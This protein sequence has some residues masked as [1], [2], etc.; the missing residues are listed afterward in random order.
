MLLAASTSYVDWS[1][2]WQI[3]VIGL[4]AGAGLV[5]VYSFGL[6]FVAAAGGLRSTSAPSA[7]RVLSLVAAAVCFLAVVGGVAYGISVMLTK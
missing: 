1:A 2:M 7:R 3:L 4:L 5:A 6:V